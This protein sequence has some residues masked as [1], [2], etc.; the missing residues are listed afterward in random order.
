MLKYEDLPKRVRDKVGKGTRRA[1]MPAAEISRHAIAIAAILRDARGL[2]PKDAE[3][4]LRK[5]LLLV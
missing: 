1:P 2:S 5:A 4:V 3:R